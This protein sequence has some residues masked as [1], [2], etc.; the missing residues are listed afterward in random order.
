MSLSADDF[1]E[2]FAALNADREPFAWQRR[3]LAHVVEHGTWPSLIDAPTG[4]GKSSAV[5]VHVFA[6]ALSAVGLAL[7]LPRRFVVV[8]SRRALVDHHHVHAECIQDKLDNSTEGVLHEVSAALEAL[9]DGAGLLVASMRG[10]VST[11]SEE[12]RAAARSW[13]DDP[14][15]CAVIS[16]TPDMYG[17]SL[18]F[19]GYMSSREAR[20][21]SAGLLSHD[22]VMMLDEAHLNQ[23]LLHSALGVA[24]DA[25]RFSD[26]LGHVPTLQVVATTATPASTFAGPREKTAI[27]V[28]DD[29]L[30][31]D[32]GGPLHQRLTRP[33]LI[34]YHGTD[35]QPAKRSA[36]DSYIAELADLARGLLARSPA[37]PGRA[38]TV[39]CVLNTV[40]CAVALA[41][42]LAKDVGAESVSCWVGRLRPLDLAQQRAERPGLFSIDG[43]DTVAFL[44]AT[45]TVEVGVDLDCAA[46]LTEVAP[47]SAL[48]QRLGRINRLGLR[49]TAEAIVVGPEAGP[50]NDRAPYR[51]E[52]LETAH[53]WLT[54]LGSA[55][56]VCPWALRTSPPPGS[57]P[58]RL[59]LSDINAEHGRLLAQTTVDLFQEPALEFWLRDD[60]SADPSPV[61][62]VMRHPLPEDD[63]SA[64]ALLRATPYDPG[65]VFPTTIKRG[66]DQLKRILDGDHHARAFLV[67]D[68]TVEQMLDT[69]RLK[70]G[71]VVLIDADHPITIRGVV[72]DPDAKSGLEQRTTAWGTPETA[73]AQPGLDPAGVLEFVTDLLD[74]EPELSPDHIQALVHEETGRE[75]EV[76][77]PPPGL[78]LDGKIPWVVL[79]PTAQVSQD[80][81]IRQDWTPG[82]TAVTLQNH[83]SAV[84]ARARRFAT[85]LGLPVAIQE[86]MD[87]A[88][89]HHDDGKSDP[90][91]QRGTLGARGEPL[92]AKGVSRSH[93]QIQR[94]KQRGG[95]PS[96]WRHEQL[97]AARVVAV[98][99]PGQLR[100]LVS[101]LAGTSHGRGR[102]FF[103]H[104]AASLLGPEAVEVS[105]R[106]AVTD[107]F[108][109]GAG[110][111]EILDRTEAHF[112]PW[113][114]AFFEAVLRAAD[115]QVS[116]EG[117]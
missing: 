113:G 48:V 91:F 60:V 31:A 39:L 18:L 117:S 86:A 59:A 112:G 5:D 46:L 106:A 54:G 82:P 14:R 83:Q 77:M 7:R 90:R 24:A 10:G 76:V 89:F 6:T 105:V 43:D 62:I 9:A 32:D 96:G 17:S 104:G 23:Q 72:S 26:K 47:A 95:L 58:L 27:G 107:L 102:P 61:G 64:L 73:V 19:R 98:L 29:D 49:P 99:D 20:P 15:R 109:T 80:A 101:R 1:V 53:A 94:D 81:E 37:A 78:I 69:T 63:T 22:T 50:Q 35:Q 65:E 71:S 88:G 38:G 87:L 92:L 68:N 36:T 97:S 33:K 67:D 30:S 74:A 116:A 93:Q 66:R 25:R 114:C 2:F 42:R 108:A 21:R 110:W 115:T 45:Q 75:E 44:V 103:P 52:D 111:D 34:S 56:D 85:D 100:D 41:D 3:L 11:R 8:V 13:L 79:R 4:A 84:A 51:G 12:D 28:T 40:D 70:P 16:A 55:A 57:D